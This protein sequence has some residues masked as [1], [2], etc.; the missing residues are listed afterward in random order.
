M[1]TVADRGILYRWRGVI[2]T[3]MGI[4]AYNLMRPWLR[5]WLNADPSHI[6]LFVGSMFALM[7][8][9]IVFSVWRRVRRGELQL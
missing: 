2:A 5:P 4:L 7:L 6:W 9:V 1:P 3:V 8:G